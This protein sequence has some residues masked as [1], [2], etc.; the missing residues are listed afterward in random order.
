MADFCE[1]GKDINPHIS[2]INNYTPPPMSMGEEYLFRIG[3]LTLIHILAMK[4]RLEAEERIEQDVRDDLQVQDERQHV[5]EFP[6]GDVHLRRPGAHH[7]PDDLEGVAFTLHVL[8]HHR[9]TPF[10][11]NYGQLHDLFI[12]GPGLSPPLFLEF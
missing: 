7:L 4:K 12:P 1:F 6:S 10:I 8:H 11:G 9:G 5:Q 3:R 2:S